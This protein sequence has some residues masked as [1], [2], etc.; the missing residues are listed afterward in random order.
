MQLLSDLP[1]KTE[2]LHIVQRDDTCVDEDDILIAP[3]GGLLEFLESVPS[4][5]IPRDS[6][7]KISVA[8]YEELQ[9]QL[10]ASLQS[11]RESETK[12]EQMRTELKQEL[13][14]QKRMHMQKLEELMEEERIQRDEGWFPAAFWR[15]VP[16]EVHFRGMVATGRPACRT[17]PVATGRLSFFCGVRLWMILSWRHNAN[18]CSA[19]KW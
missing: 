13:A 19:P 15:E 9:V 6:V 12:R 18:C 16:S 5:Q 3:P 1:V 7:E 17:R 4:I 14:E 10:G 2:F 8:K 11:F